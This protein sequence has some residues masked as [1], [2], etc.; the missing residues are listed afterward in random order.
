MPRTLAQ[1]HKAVALGSLG[2]IVSTVGFAAGAQTPE[3]VIEHG[4][5]ISF[6]LYM[7]KDNGDEQILNGTGP[8]IVGTD[9][10][11]NP[12]SVGESYNQPSANILVGWDEIFDTR[13]GDTGTYSR[14]RLT[15]E[16]SDGSPFITQSAIDEGFRLLRWE[17][18]AVTNPVFDAFEDAFDFRDEV[19]SIPLVEASAVFFDGNAQLNAL[20]YGFTLGI[21]SEW[22]GTDA[23]PNNLFTVGTD[24]NRIEITYDY[25]PTFIPV[26]A[27]AAAITGLGLGLVRRRRI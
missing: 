18:G 26:P 27:T 6:L 23:I 9:T 11:I 24:V 13:P 10:L 16:T 21:G 4:D 14:I 1:P 3:R 2:V 12:I 5:E 22:D 7:A 20:D 8:G 17:I 15:I 19:T 25:D